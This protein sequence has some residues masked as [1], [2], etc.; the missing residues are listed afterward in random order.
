[1]DNFDD[2]E[3]AK[4]HHHLMKRPPVDIEFSDLTYSVPHG[5]NGEKLY[6]IYYFTDLL[7]WLY[8]KKIVQILPTMWLFQY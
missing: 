6:K 2:I 3:S 4:S 8:E 1:M 5:P 7:Q